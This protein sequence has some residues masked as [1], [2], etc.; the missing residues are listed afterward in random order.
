VEQAVGDRAGKEESMKR[1]LLALTLVL[2][3]SLIVGAGVA[4][5][6]HGTDYARGTVDHFGTEWRLSARSNF[7]ETGAQGQVQTILENQDPNFVVT[8]AVTCLLVVGNTASIVAEVTEA[9]GGITS[10]QS[11]LISTTDSGKFQN[12]P[13]TFRSFLSATPATSVCPPP[14]PFQSPVLDSEF[15]VHESFG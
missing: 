5:A 6:D 11:T 8:G 9:R 1:M 3:L 13:D 14:D 12:M 10:A 2:L 7:N 4:Y 15:I